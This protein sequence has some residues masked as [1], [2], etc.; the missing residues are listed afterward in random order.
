MNNNI[1]FSR[2]QFMKESALASMGLLAPRISMVGQARAESP[3]VAGDKGSSGLLENEFLRIEVNPRSGDITGLFNKRTGKEYIAAKQWARVFRLNVPCQKYVTGFNADYSA[4]SLDSWRQTNCIIS[5]DR[6]SGKQILKA[7]YPTLES[8]AGRFE[9]ELSYSIRLPDNSD[10]AFFQL[11]IANHSQYRIKEVFFPW[12]SGVGAVEDAR[13]DIFVTSE[14][15]RQVADL[16]FQ[17]GAN[18][19]EYPFLLDSPVWPSG[20]YSLSMPWINFGGRREGLYLASLTRECRVH[21]LI[22]QNFGDEKE[23]IL[24]IAWAFAPYVEPGR[25]WRSPEIVLSLHPG[26]WHAAADKYRKSLEGW[27]QKIDT[28]PDFK[29]PFASFN[30]FFTSQNFDQ[31]TDLAEDIRKY[32]L[33]DLVMWNFGDYYPNVL[34]EDNLSVDP[35][36]LGVFTPQWG[37]LARLKAANAKAQALGVRTGIIFSQRLWNKDALTPELRALAEKWVIRGESGDPLSETWHH[38]HLGAAQWSHHRP[39]FGH[40]EYIMC[41]AVKDWQNFAIHNIVGVLSQAGYSTMFYDQAAV[42]T[43]LCFNPEHHHSDANAPSLSAYDFVKSLRAAMKEANP[44]AILIGEGWNVVVSQGTDMGWSWVGPP[45]PEVF[46]YTLPWVFNAIATDVD[47]GQAS[48]Y[49]IL[50]IHLAIVAKSNENGKNLSDF[51]E[52]AQHL[53][54]LASFREKTERFW[55]NGT[56][57][58][59]VGLRVSGAFGKVYTTPNEVAI[60]IGNLVDKAVDASFELDFHQYSVSAVNYSVVSTSGRGE[61]GKAEKSGAALKDTKSLAPFEV[62]AVVFERQPSQA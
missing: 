25:S 26:D 36:R 58:D 38:Q 14:T 60:I 43:N 42:E 11:E 23:P 35:P 59:D 57:R 37:G 50:G 47:R 18:W 24:A 16:K 9:I 31:I 54:R 1:D 22:L 10:E 62:V 12:I 5:S 52:F 46:R 20:P 2:R 48:K 6:S 4:N 7:Q 30:S 28:P 39:Y 8:P 17:Q 56:F 21:M 55:V 19:E 41:D 44:N 51:P 61:N 13:T 15:I 34:E 40:L 27:N 32:G 53:A 3:A 29:K 45:N 49:F 33:R